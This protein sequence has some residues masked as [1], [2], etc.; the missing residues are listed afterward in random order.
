MQPIDKGLFHGALFRAAETNGLASLISE[1]AADKLYAL[2]VRML[3]VNEQFNLTAI[4]EPGR[5]ILLH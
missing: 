1:K 5:V 3:T 2:T 4:K